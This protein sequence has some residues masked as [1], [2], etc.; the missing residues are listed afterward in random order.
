MKAVMG[1]FMHRL[2]IQGVGLA[3]F[4]SLIWIVGPLLSI[5][6]RTPLESSTSRLLLILALVVLWG[7]YQLFL[8]ASARKKNRQLVSDLAAPAA[9]DDAQASIEEA[10]TEEA[11][12]LRQKFQEALQLL[13]TSGPGD[14][15]GGGSLYDL[16]WYVIIG[17]PGT[18]KTTLL[19]NSGLQSRP[20]SSPVFVEPES[21]PTPAR[22]NPGLRPWARHSWST[23]DSRRSFRLFLLGVSPKG[24][25][26]ADLFLC[27]A[28]G[29]I[30]KYDHRHRLRLSRAMTASPRP[31]AC[32][33]P[34]SSSATPLDG[35]R[36][37]QGQ[38]KIF[39]TP[40]VA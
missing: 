8:Q 39:S 35:S 34:D 33:L 13:K 28:C 3:A 1:L 27:R 18:G 32:A 12:H 9:G 7:G 4:C 24:A 38:Y 2:V 29:S 15:R 17:G 23:R 16:P 26:G 25:V 10:R 37:D 40:G 21:A 30:R 36:R 31:C 11:A 22:P 19:L 5:A 14:R 6:H 20:D